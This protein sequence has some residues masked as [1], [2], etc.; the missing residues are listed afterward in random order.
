L[1]AITGLNVIFTFLVFSPIFGLT[2]AYPKPRFSTP[3]SN[4][5]VYQAM[6][7]PRPYFLIWS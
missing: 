3:N 4:W 2:M 6:P 1:T 5:L 7:M